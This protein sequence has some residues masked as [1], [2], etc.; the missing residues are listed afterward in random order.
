MSEQKK[1][2]SPTLLYLLSYWP[3]KNHSAA[4]ERI[5]CHITHLLEGGF[6]VHVAA[7]G[8]PPQDLELEF[9]PKLCT[10]P[11]LERF[12]INDPN[13]INII[14]AINPQVVLFDKYT[15]EEKYSWQVFHGAPEALRILDTVDLHWLRKGREVLSK[16]S[17]HRWTSEAH[18]WIFDVG[19]TIE[20][21][22]DVFLRE[23]AA[24]LRSDLALVVSDA[25]RKIL[26]HFHFI[27]ENQ[28][29]LQS[30]GQTL[31]TENLGELKSFHERKD[32]YFVGHYQHPPNRDAINW[33]KKTLWPSI[34]RHFLSENTAP[35]AKE[36]PS[37]H[38]FSAG[39]SQEQKKSLHAPQEGFLVHGPVDNIPFHSLRVNLAP[40][41]SGAG[42]KGKIT[43]GWSWGIPVVTTSI[44]AEGMT[45]ESRNPSHDKVDLGSQTLG[46]GG[47]IAANAEEI[48]MSSYHLYTTFELWHYC[49]SVGIEILQTKFCPKKNAEILRN[50]ISNSLNRLSSLR[51]SRLLSAIL[52][53]E[54]MRATEYFSRWIQLK[55]SSFSTS[56]PENASLKP[57]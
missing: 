48:G 31:P 52:Q 46:F 47:L 17:P 56:I 16:K 50:T 44:G 34:R 21:A 35:Q 27:D 54:S 30:L 12:K 5:F 2:T 7:D 29:I 9:A 39:M 22:R 45:L 49:Q 32:F 23:M 4:S 41:R 43:Q 24:I 8:P 10:L 37:L 15:T 20:A 1:T 51:Q 55:A 25:E 38:I 53:H 3:K 19:E 14:R 33:L 13:G 6:N 18:G 57:K 11:V 42:I 28:I 36:T 26:T 40:L